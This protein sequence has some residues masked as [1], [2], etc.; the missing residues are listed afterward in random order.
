MSTNRQLWTIVAV[1]A[2]ASIVG[3]SSMVYALHVYGSMEP[4]YWQGATGNGQSQM[5]GMMGAWGYLT[6]AQIDSISTS[7]PTVAANNTLIFSGDSV[8]ILALMGPMTEGQNMYSFAIDN[9]TNPTL[10]IP[11]GTKVT[12]VVVNVDTDAYH[13][14]TLTSAVPPYPYSFMPMMMGSVASTGAL[15]PSS[16]GFASQQVSFTV[17]GGLYY[18]CPVPGHA[19]SGMYGMIKPG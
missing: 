11:L 7:Q 15:P 16:S 17:N 4:R 9:L 6:G 13:G 18:V 3:L 2:V 8:K 19:Q 5:G 14:L 1:V 12:M 10:V